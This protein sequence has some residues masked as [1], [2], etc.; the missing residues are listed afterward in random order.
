MS[1]YIISECFIMIILY[2]SEVIKKARY[3]DSDCSDIYLHFDPHSPYFET[4]CKWQYDCMS[5][6]LQ[7]YVL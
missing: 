7:T 4:H 3:P 2:P 6:F 1:E 5:L